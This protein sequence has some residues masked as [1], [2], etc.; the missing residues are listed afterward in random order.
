MTNERKAFIAD[1]E[2]A[3]ENANR[4]NAKILGESR[5]LGDDAT[6]HQKGKIE[7]GFLV[8]PEILTELE[9][10][11]RAWKNGDQSSL[12]GEQVMEDGA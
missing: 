11:L 4:L 3:L 2:L 1:L 10:M 12:K 7:G 9:P 8:V 5:E 6:P